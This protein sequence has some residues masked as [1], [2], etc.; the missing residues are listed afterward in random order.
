MARPKT[1]SD[2]EILQAAHRVIS[3]RGFEGFSLAEVARE[4]GI[5]RSAIIQRFESTRA[6]KLKLTDKMIDRFRDALNSLPVI[7]SGDGL[8]ALMSFIGDMVKGR[9]NLAVFMQNLQ[10]DFN[11]DE[12]NA[13][14][15]R[16][17]E[18]LR[19]AISA[20]MPEV[21]ID[22]DSAVLA[23]IANMGGSLMQWQIWSDADASTYLVE[24]TRAWLAL[25]GIAFSQTEPTVPLKV[26]GK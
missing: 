6:L 23:F 1:A 26:A 22:H 8:I 5:S 15:L 14:E 25:A 19:Q 16:R 20:R 10:A 12:F 21:K 4:V 18:T 24:R 3:R 17:I 13:L 9:D 2:E 11:D 7:R